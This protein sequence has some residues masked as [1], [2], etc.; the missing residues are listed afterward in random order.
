MRRE[1]WA[2]V[3][4]L[5]GDPAGSGAFTTQALTVPHP[6]QACGAPS[7]Q[8]WLLLNAAT[9]VGGGVGV[10]LLDGASLAPLGNFS[11]PAEFTGNSVRWPAAWATAGQPLQ[12]VSRDLSSLAGSSVAVRVALRHAQLFAWE[13]QCVAAGATLQP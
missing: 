1:G 13:L 8:L 5:P 3:R 4:S 10:T 6:G 7:A 12:P 11:T 9:S 2:G